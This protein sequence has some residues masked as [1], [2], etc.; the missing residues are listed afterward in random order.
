M[1]RVHATTILTVRRGENVVM[2]GDGQVT[3]GDMVLKHRARKLRRMHNNTI[4][5]GFAGSA[6]DGI[7]LLER[8]EAELERSNGNLR[9]AAVDLAKQWRTDRYLRRLEAEL[10]TA[11]QDAILVLSGD[12]NIIEPDDDAA[13]IGSGSPYAL[14][15]ARALLRHTE[16]GALEIAQAAMRLAGEMDLYTNADVVL[17]TLP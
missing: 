15:A 1:S 14:S 10:L 3:V 16:M 11:S 5:A 8:F 13:G 6:A 12:G 2:I 4:L 17:E 9:R 7:T